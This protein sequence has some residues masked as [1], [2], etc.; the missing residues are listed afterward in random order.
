MPF[1]IASLA[2]AGGTLPRGCNA[3][4][5]AIHSGLAVSGR[6]GLAAPSA[7][8]PP[9]GP[10]PCPRRCRR[11]ARSSS[12]GSAARA[13]HDRR[14]GARTRRRTCRSR[15]RW[16]RRAGCAGRA[17]SACWPSRAARPCPRSPLRAWRPSRR[18]RP[19]PVAVAAGAR[20]RSRAGKRQAHRTDSGLRLAETAPFGRSRGD[21]EGQGTRRRGSVG[22]PELVA[23]QDVVGEG[24]ELAQAVGLRNEDGLGDGV[25]LRERGRVRRRCRP[26]AGPASAGAR[27]APGRCRSCCGPDRYR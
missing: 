24:H 23:T 19:R 26:P 1:A 22:W 6:I 11:R 5:A 20:G 3:S 13:R 15:A 18:R 12:R 27:D 10:R 7:R 25:G 2:S 14:P 17:P 16:R 9:S 4:A 21:D 8:G